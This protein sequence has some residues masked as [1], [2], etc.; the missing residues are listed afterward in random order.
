MNFFMGPRLEGRLSKTEQAHKLQ[1]VI[2][3]MRR[4]GLSALSGASMAP[5]RAGE[6][7]ALPAAAY[8]N[9]H[10]VAHRYYHPRPESR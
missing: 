6:T 7:S 4:K 10:K 2:D 9:P 5:V 3:T 8:C 1:A